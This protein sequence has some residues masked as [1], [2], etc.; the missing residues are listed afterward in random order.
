[1][2][3]G[4]VMA[5]AAFVK[6][7]LDDATLQKGLDR[8]SSKL[9]AFK[10][11]TE[12]AVNQMAAAFTALNMPIISAMKSF[13][14]FDDQIRMVRAVTGAAADSM[15]EL[16]EQ[17]KQLGRET[18][19]TASQ[20]A[21]GMLSLGRMGLS[22]KE[23]Q[24]AIK[25][26]MDL[27]R[28]TGTDLG[29]A[30]E[31]AANQ[32]RVF[33]MQSEDMTKIA[34]ILSVTANSS[35]QTLTDLGEAL[36]MAAPHAK[37]AG[38]D[39]KDT[40]AALGILANM[41]IRG[42]MAGTALGKSYKK[43]ADPKVIDYLKSYGVE[44]LNADGSMRRMR[45]TLVDIAKVMK[46]MTNAQQITFAEKIFDARGSLGGGTLAVNT[47]AID[48]L[49]KKLD[50]SEGAAAKA[51]EEMES[52]I[53]GALR[54]LGSAAEGVS[55]AFGEL[56]SVSFLPLVEQISDA[57]GWL[58]KLVQENGKAIASFTKGLYVFLGAGAVVKILTMIYSGLTKMLVPFK[59][60]LFMLDAGAKGFLKWATSE[61]VAS[62][63]AVLH[64]KALGT[65]S[66]KQLFLTATT[67]KHAKAVLTA[68]IS[69]MVAAKRAAGASGLRVAGYYAEAVAAKVAAGATLALKAALDFIA[70]HP[71]TV[72][73]TAIAAVIGGLV[74]ATQL[75][76]KELE[77][78]AEKSKELAKNAS[79]HREEGDTRRKAAATQMKRLQQLEEISKKTRLSAD[80]MKEAE[81]II[82][83]LDP[84]GGSQWAK[85]DTLAGK[86]TLAADAQERLNAAMKAAARADLEAEY[87]AQEKAIADLEKQYNRT[88]GFWNNAGMTARDFFANNVVGQIVTLG[89]V[90]SNEE[91][92]A[93]I[94]S[95][96]DVEMKKLIAIKK[97][98]QALEAGEA[99]AV[100]GEGGKTIEDVITETG[101]AIEAETDKMEDAEKKLKS[102]DE[103]LAKA[104]RTSFENELYEIKT[105]REEYA[106]NIEM[107]MAQK[108]AELEVA[109]SRGESTEALQAEIDELIKRKEAA[110]AGY[111]EMEKKARER[112]AA[113]IAKGQKDFTSF[114]GG[115]KKEDAQKR[116]T[117]SLD[118]MAEAKDPGLKSFLGVL[119]QKQSAALTAAVQDYNAK[120]KMF[121]DEQSEGGKELTDAEKDVLREIQ[122]A[123]KDGRS[124][125]DDFTNRL[126]RAQDATGEKVK[127]Q[128]ARVMAAWSLDEL[129]RMFDTSAQDRTAAAT[130][131]LVEQQEKAISLQEK[132]NK[133]LKKIQNNATLVYG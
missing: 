31:I 58:R 18:S 103:D 101:E 6:L 61:A 123:I 59:T 121:L 33:G 52:G 84:F 77:K 75:E 131:K 100:T 111:D 120:L 50:E 1:M 130:E 57:C 44:T 35:A 112:E 91:K 73:L 8:A 12:I 2:P 65:L 90:D 99:G 69:E 7:T 67:K 36:K 98:M 133:S 29:Q 87:A 82:N 81:S 66:A 25:P 16:T 49:V 15:A 55:L 13:A 110:V 118:S 74:I 54:K 24:G 97:R 85:L 28:V 64:G 40:A 48:A 47:D 109:K 95:Q 34:D 56:I 76:A 114:F 19:F 22:T 122:E 21:S 4:A 126:K 41:G 78:A 124:R 20:V 43:L 23:I 26:M 42:S 80:Q 106:K 53:G 70:A 128:D 116:L 105:L 83:K 96:V 3:I 115:L 93:G 62:K 86:I 89:M 71:V 68:S 127:E 60:F 38:A 132:G 30:A 11:S 92:N 9:K 102:L 17:A 32:M 14:A 129:N 125:M 39:L 104:R 108:K 72:A 79:E 94:Q 46:T 5:G 45:D 10:A 27:A 119:M 63:S 107:L 51:A 88:G 113:R 117:R 37:R